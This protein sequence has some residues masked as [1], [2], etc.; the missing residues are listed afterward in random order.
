MIAAR[1]TPSRVRLAGLVVSVAIAIGL[2]IFAWTLAR[3]GITLGDEGYLLSQALAIASGKVP[4]RDLDLFVSPGVWLLL[5]GLFKLVEPSVIVSRIP[6]AVGLCVNAWL[7]ARIARHIVRPACEE[8][9][10]SGVPDA[11]G[12]AAAG[13]VALFATIALWAFPAWSFSYYSPYAMAFAAAALLVYLSA[14]KHES[15]GLL[16]VCGLFIG[17]STLFKHNYGAYAAVGLGV[18]DIL[19]IAQGEGTP[20]RKFGR[21][22]A[23]G[24][25]M[26]LGLT[27]VLAPLVWWLAT[28]G[29]LDAAR[30]LLF[31]RPFVDFAQH[32]SIAYLPFS[33]MWQQAVMTQ[34]AGFIYMA[35]VARQLPTLLAW[36]PSVINTGRFFNGLLYWMPPLALL[37]VVGFAGRDLRRGRTSTAAVA[38]FSAAMFLGVFPRADFTHLMHVYQ[39]VIPVVVGVGVRMLVV[40]R[41]RLR[42]SMVAL[43]LVVGAGYSGVGA[44]YYRHLM[45]EVVEPLGV[46]RGGVLLTSL[47]A[48]QLSYE[49]SMLQ[50]LT[51]PGEPIVAM[52]GLSMFNFLA[53]RPLPGAYANYYAVHIGHDRGESARRDLDQAGVRW[54]VADYNNFFSDPDRMVDFAPQLTNYLVHNFDHAY[55]VNGTNRLVLQRR[56]DPRPQAA[57]TDLLPFCEVRDVAGTQFVRDHLLFRAM[58][59]SPT[60]ARPSTGGVWTF[61]RIDGVPDHASLHF[62][63]EAMRPYYADPDATFTA[64]AWAFAD[65]DDDRSSSTPLMA[66]T[67]PF[68]APPGW[69]SPAARR[70]DID[71]G[72]FAGSSITIAFRTRVKGRV[73][74]NPFMIPVSSVI[75]RSMRIE[76]PWENAGPLPEETSASADDQL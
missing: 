70:F 67:R 3:R 55:S 69:A 71:L 63:V 46:P 43:F 56:K 57:W 33:D 21:V 75:W 40:T 61:C 11:P 17:L 29:A 7:G 41:G 22:V 27:V 53:D 18:A 9:P 28:E 44:V 36:S 68:I 31:V 49:V 65:G 2:P 76:S 72:E 12:I 58:Y 32:H 4:Y 52:P 66:M 14:A 10:D 6:A 60:H 64:E 42:W 23:D 24:T 54:V 15:R 48:S 51:N 34:V 38:I 50:A 39:A 35:D 26:L 16:F 20:L 47:E 19:R 73:E 62:E 30:E 1:L 74:G 8:D 59:H 45:R 13:T 25:A 37:G 5:A